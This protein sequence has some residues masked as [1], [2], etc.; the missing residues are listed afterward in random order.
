VGPP[1]LGPLALDL[2]ELELLCGGLVWHGKN[3]IGA[4]RVLDGP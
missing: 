1:S 3:V 4:V 2:G